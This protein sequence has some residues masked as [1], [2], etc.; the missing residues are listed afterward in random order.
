MIEKLKLEI[1]LL[2]PENGDCADCVQRLQE[3]LQLHKGILEAHVDESADPPRLCLHYDPNLISLAEVERHARQEGIAIQQRYRHRDLR[4]EGLDCADCAVKLEKGVGRL[5]G[6]FYTAVDFA[7]GRMRV[8]Y[9]VEKV[10]Q[11]DIVSRIRKL[12]YDVAEKEEVVQ[13]AETA[14]GGLRGLLAFMWGRRRDM[15]TLL[16]GL[17]LLL[18][19]GL[20]TSGVPLGVTHALY[21]LAI[22]VGGYYVARKGL[23]GV[24]INRELDINFLMTV[25]ALGA[26]AIGAWE[27]GALV[28]FLF[29]LGE[30]L[31]SYTMDRARNAIRSLMELAP[32]EATVLRPCTDC[33][34]HLGRPL[35]DGTT[36]EGGPCP[37][38]EPHEER[39]DVAE[40]AVGDRILVRPG[41]R[42]PMDGRV[43]QGTSAVNQAPVTGESVP[44]E[45]GPGDEVFA[46][47]VNGEG[48]LEIEV[49]RLAEDSTISRI[50]HM[51]EE[52]QAQKAPSQRWVDRFARYYTPA[53]VGLAILIAAVPPLLFGQPFLEP[54][55]GG[56]GWLYRA[57]A[58]LIIACPCALV[59][60]TPVSIV[61][62]ISNAAR[63]GVLVK[64]GA[65]LE[66]AGSLQ[67]IA[68]DKT[69]TLTR[70]EPA[71]TDVVPLDDRSPEEVLALAASVESR[72][73]H[74]LAQAVVAAA[75]E[76]GLSFTP[77]RDFQA[78]TGRGASGFL[79]GTRVVV[80]NLTL[81]A[82]EGV[83]VPEELRDRIERLEEEGK[84]T[85][86]LATANGSGWTFWGIIG[87]ADTV[88]PDAREAVAAL[89]RLGI[90]RT[91]MLTGDNERTAR[92]VAAQAGVDEARANLLPEEKVAAVEDLLA[93]YGQVAMV[94]DGVNDAPALAR[95]TVGIAMGGAGTDQALETADIVLMADD[96]SKLPFAIRLSRRTLSVVRQNI[97][98]SLLVKAAF[99]A[100]ALPG[101][102]TL[103]MAVFADVGASLLVILNGMRLLRLRDT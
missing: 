60:S 12:G 52:A 42:I 77:A 86:V 46:G 61:S 88:R 98:F 1:P 39:V 16:S 63:R 73:E 2:L 93:E 18:A 99:M 44:V 3:A 48:A 78:L 74:P 5:D 21:G 100:L 59:I 91:V 11:A 41:E 50:I 15:L 103:W 55:T 47:T 9:D 84:T 31:E 62:A 87:V 92:A 14:P 24:W 38:C 96:L 82:D 28:V 85:M 29:S 32:A 83:Q 81:F 76:R 53:V 79:N 40:L 71:V 95:A 89:K 17:L 36:Y 13:T 102:A 94:G 37:W 23:V 58:L 19:F 30:T 27:E 25:A 10:D 75:E 8:E 54:P 26:M 6:V 69:G 57:L 45:K 4:L 67:V 20:E 43:L 7:T 49:T 22:G 51:V 101:L 80:G 68:F 35:P 33:E 90:R 64:G 70:G 97:G 66:A 56:H 72:S 34:E 65:Y